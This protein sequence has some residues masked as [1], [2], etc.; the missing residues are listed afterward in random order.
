MQITLMWLP[1]DEA[2]PFNR[3]AIASAHALED[4][5]NAT[6]VLKDIRQVWA[7]VVQ[8]YRPAAHFLLHTH[9]RQH[10]RYKHTF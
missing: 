2:E 5:A 6:A 10:W 7:Y 8:P 3:T 1:Y 4:V 9:H